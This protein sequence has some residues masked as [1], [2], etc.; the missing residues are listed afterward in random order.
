MSV[1]S[2]LE[3][4]QYRLEEQGLH[5]GRFSIGP[6]QRGQ[7]ITVGNALRRVLVSELSGV[8]ITNVK[9]LHFD[10]IIHEFSTLPGV[11][12]SIFELLLSLKS[13]VI[14][15][16]NSTSLIEPQKCL[17]SLRGPGVVKA[18]AIQLPETLQLADPNQYI[19]TLY[20]EDVF[21]D[22][23]LTIQEGQG[24]YVS[25]QDKQLDIHS[26]PVESTFVPVKK[27]HYIVED[28]EVG[29]SEL[30]K[31]ERIL[32]E[33]WTNGSIYPIEA[34]HQG[35]QVLMDLFMPLLE[36]K[37]SDED[38]LPFIL[39]TI[40]QAQPAPIIT[41]PGS[42]ETLPPNQILIED[43]GLSVRSYNCLKSA[44]I[45]TISDLLDYSKQNLLEIKH[46]GKKSA[47]EVVQALQN[48]LGIELPN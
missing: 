26:I 45:H 37:E 40:T 20:S 7:G 21:F 8:A 3:C 44:H 28:Y 46:F 18:N 33:V 47:E 1:T 9:F 23:E 2:R 4:L 14:S 32:L 48:R 27:V 36:L 17:L 43:L 10:S 5:Y 6:I 11:R 24:L 25:Q 30:E 35:A 29:N 42:F 13:V 22:L 16:V 34:I 31:C 12:E 38:K 19:A 15:K 39:P 41:T